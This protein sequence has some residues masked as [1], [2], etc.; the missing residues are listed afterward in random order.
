MK[1]N[2]NYLNLTGIIGRK[3][4][5]F[6]KKIE[7][8]LFGLVLLSVINVVK[9]IASERR[10]KLTKQRVQ[11][12][13]LIR[14]VKLIASE[15]RLKSEEDVAL[16]SFGL[17]VVKLIASERRLKYMNQLIQTLLLHLS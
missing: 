8:F 10:L 4:N 2:K 7:I 1:Y 13:C 5:S 3:V 6:R 16:A 15:R 17:N 12:K 14:V 9:L 11:C